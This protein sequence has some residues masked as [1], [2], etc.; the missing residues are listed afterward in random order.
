M[1]SVSIS[2]NNNIGHVIKTRFST[3]LRL[4]IFFIILLFILLFQNKQ[5]IK[6]NKIAEIADTASYTTPCI[7]W[8]L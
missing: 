5:K 3:Y 7:S 4:L 2:V 8:Y 1:S 6:L